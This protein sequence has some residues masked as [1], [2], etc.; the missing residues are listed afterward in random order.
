MWFCTFAISLLLQ[1]VHEQRVKVNRCQIE[2]REST[3]RYQAGN[4]LTGIREQDVR[5]VCAQAMRQLI[6]VNTRD[7]ENAALLNFTQ[8]RS[9]IASEEV[10]VTRNTTSYTSS[11]SWLEAVSRSS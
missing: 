5:A 4:A 2:L 3:A 8:E 10:T 9:V 1:I 11:A 7:G 6:P